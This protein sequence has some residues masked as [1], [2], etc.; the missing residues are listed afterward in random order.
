MG[1]IIARLNQLQKCDLL[2]THAFIPDDEMG[3]VHLK[4]HTKL[5]V[6]LKQKTVELVCIFA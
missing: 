5:Q 1:H 3:V 2:V 4:C 6:F